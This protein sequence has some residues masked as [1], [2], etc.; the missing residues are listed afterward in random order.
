M[1]ILIITPYLPWPLDSGG[2][3]AQYSTLSAL[4]EHHQFILV[5]PE[6]DSN[7]I[8]NARELETQLPHVSI[9][10]AKII[11]SSSLH[12]YANKK[13]NSVCLLKRF[14]AYSKI[15]IKK[16]V[17]AVSGM[18]SKTLKSSQEIS[19][20]SLVKHGNTM[21]YNPFT[22]LCPQ[23]LFEI[24]IALKENPELIQIEFADMLSLLA[25]LP[26]EIPRLFIHHQ[27]HWIYA[28]R[29]LTSC[30]SIPYGDYIKE[31]MKLQELALLS[32][33]DA[34]ITFS[35][36]DSKAISSELSNIPIYVSPFPIP[37][38]VEKP[39]NHIVLFNNTFLF[40]GSSKH[41][42]N[43]QAAEWML[44][45]IWPL[46]V[47]RKPNTKLK[48]IGDWPIEFK[49]YW[50]NKNI[51]FNG[52][53]DDLPLAMRGCVLLVPLKIGSG[54]RTKI[55]AAMSQC[56]PVVSTTIGCEG[57]LLTPNVDILVADTATDFV[58][59]SVSLASDAKLFEKVALSALRAAKNYSS[60]EVCR[61]RNYIYNEVVKLKHQPIN[62][63]NKC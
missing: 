1:K 42:P 15:N 49:Q 3:A 60:A 58:N 47:E 43:V 32:N 62:K 53:V 23:L 9:R 59:A 26:K 33:V 51:S 6:Q 7:S 45:E 52:Y 10:L 16:V 63:L 14:Y 41:H 22:V 37:S 19:I 34:I 25:W 48:L 17:R 38:D 57:L 55:L 56:V 13:I 31:Y 61:R 20:P 29:L 46:I 24:Q 35:D 11:Q 44:R 54:I 30:R 28:E 36:I 40:L 27:L 2:K 8:E 18:I 4:A 50:S 21:P 39:P 12:S 5:C